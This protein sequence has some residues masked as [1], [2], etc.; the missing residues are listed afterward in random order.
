[1]AVPKK[2]KSK[3]KKNLKKL[4]WHNKVLIYAKK[5]LILFKKN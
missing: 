3:S 2:R 1:M 4:Y 5:A